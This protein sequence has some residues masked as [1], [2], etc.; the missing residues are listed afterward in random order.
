M[1][2]VCQLLYRGKKG[3]ELKKHR[4]IKILLRESMTVNTK[5]VRVLIGQLCLGV[6]RICKHLTYDVRSIGNLPFMYTF[7]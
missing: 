7:N 3:E 4:V 5:A 2:N 6:G 1:R